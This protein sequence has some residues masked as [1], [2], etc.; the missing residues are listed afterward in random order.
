MIGESETE[1][2]YVTPPTEEEVETRAA[3]SALRHQRNMQLL[4]MV[5]SGIGTVLA[6]TMTT[7]VIVVLVR[8]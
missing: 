5:F 3:Y 2:A 4:T 7:L 8:T 6:V 1:N